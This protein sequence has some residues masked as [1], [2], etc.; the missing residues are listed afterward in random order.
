MF[1]RLDRIMPRVL[2]EIAAAR[3]VRSPEVERNDRRRLAEV[4]RPPHPIPSPKGE[5]QKIASFGG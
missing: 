5:A 4:R 2:A 1:E 3:A